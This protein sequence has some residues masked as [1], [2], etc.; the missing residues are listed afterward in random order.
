MYAAL[1]ASSG[2]WLTSRFH[3]LSGGRS[4]RGPGSAPPS[5]TPPCC[6]PAG[7][8]RT[9][10]SR[11]ISR[12]PAPTVRPPPWRNDSTTCRTSMKPSRGA[13]PESDPGWRP[14]QSERI[15]AHGTASGK[16]DARSSHMARSPTSL[17]QAP[18]FRAP[19]LR[20]GHPLRQNCARRDEHGRV[21]PRAVSHKGRTTARHHV[22]SGAEVRPMSGSSPSCAGRAA[23]TAGGQ[24]LTT[25][26]IVAASEIEAAPSLRTPFKYQTMTAPAGDCHTRSVHPSPLKS[27]VS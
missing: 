9:D 14:A 11:A 10:R 19:A 16:L 27:P 15:N 23:S 17:E 21:A 12:T 5:V 26:Q 3:Q 6:A 25:R 24:G 4:G 1:L 20:M 18:S 7:G 2:A 13:H 22:P 8:P